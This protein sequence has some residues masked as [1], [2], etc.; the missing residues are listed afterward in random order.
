MPDIFGIFGVTYF[1]IRSTHAKPLLARVAMRV[2][3]LVALLVAFVVLLLAQA[4]AADGAAE[5]HIPKLTAVPALED[6]LTMQPHGEA[7]LQMV[8]VGPFTQREPHDGEPAS[9]KTDAYLGYDST[10]LYVVFVCF[11]SNP[12]K[13]RAR[14][15]RREDI[16]DDDTVEVML[17][18]YRDHR[19]AFVFQ[20]SPLGVQWDGIF[21]EA[22]TTAGN[23]YFGFDSSFDTVWD[24]KGKV[25]SQ[26]FVVWFAIPFRSLRFHPADT[27]SWGIILNRSIQA[28][29]ENTF[30]PR[31]S[32]RIGSRLTQ[33]ATLDGIEHIPAGRNMQFIPYGILDSFH[34]LN[35][36]GPGNPYFDNRLV[37][38]K[39]GLDAKFVL[40]KSLT[41][42]VTA[43]PDFSQVESDEPQVTV[44]QRF[45]VYFPEKRPF[46][47]EN[48][49]FFATPLNLLFTRN[50]ANPE[51]G[52]RLSGRVGAYG[53]GLL[54]A[55][56]RSP[57]LEVPYDSPEAGKKATFVVGRVTRDFGRQS[58]AGAIYTDREFNGAFNRVGGLD[59]RVKL[60]E[61]WTATGQAV[62]SST[63]HLDGSYQAGPADKFNV[64]RSG[65]HFNYDLTYND[66]S[67]GFQT[68]TGF[69]NRVD[70]RSLGQMAT[71]AFRPQKGIIVDWGPSLL[72][73][74]AWDHKGL[75]LDSTVDAGITVEMRAGTYFQLQPYSNFHERLRPSDGFGNLT[76]QDYHEHLTSVYAGTSWLKQV[77]V[78]GQYSFGELINFAPLTAGPVLAK[79]DSGNFNASYR[80][81]SSLKIDNTYLFARLRD[82]E[83]GHA[84][85]NNHIFRSKWNWQFTRELSVRAIA[86][87]STTLANSGF[88][89]LSSTKQLNGDF[90]IT[91]L[92]HPGTAIYFGYNSDL[93]NVD[94]R[95]RTD[96]AGNLLRTQD[97]LINDGRLA[98]IKVSWL[99][100]Y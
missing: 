90:L 20:S 83:S 44:N 45:A 46:F 52:A 7:A 79:A 73:Q 21:S 12:K 62:V 89:S 47:I 93:Q 77:I 19:R 65:Y 67:P 22:N 59:A 87:Y 78:G 5:L 39:V 48:S 63:Q 38:G 23:D 9:Q 33:E 95:L 27:Q 98:F 11:D 1:A 32:K 68:R 6:F 55:N 80:P 16:Y 61:N 41:L 4:H 13:I 96:G 72:V 15:S 10:R 56:D 99:F 25:T 50:I 37:G 74:E 42:D 30:W 97:R 34:S 75:R 53:L 76:D 14:L 57:G 66:V 69:V 40:H 35:T 43:N 3:T 58:R 28:S 36:R 26:G 17:D 70:I 91:Y 82:L 92:V 51:Y 2:A 64:Q 8:K 94:P 29:S 86:E 100:R 84:I 71:Y 85:F 31:V 88:T 24:N 18:T 54:L 49:D 81:F 60:S